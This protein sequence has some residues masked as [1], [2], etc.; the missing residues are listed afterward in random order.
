MCRLPFP[1]QNALE[2]H[3][4]VTP[5]HPSCRICSTGFKQQAG[6]DAVRAPSVR[7]KST[8][9]DCHEAQYPSASIRST[10]YTSHRTYYSA[11]SANHTHRYCS[12]NGT[13]ASFVNGSSGS[14]FPWPHTIMTRP[15]TLLANFAT[16]DSRT[17]PRSSR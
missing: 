13:D 16:S 12:L 14:L 8:S 3:Y 7:T 15:R 5:E 9:A 6:L 10:S 2:H 17:G 11:S 4:L 1:R